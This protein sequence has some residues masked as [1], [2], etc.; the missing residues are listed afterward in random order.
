[1]NYVTYDESGKL[2]GAY[3]Q[4]LHPLHVDCHIEVSGEQYINWTSYRANAARDGIER[5]PPIAPTLEQLRDAAKTGRQ[6]TVDAITVA[7]GDKVFDGDEVSQG[8]M[9]RA[10][11]VADITGQT[12]CTWVMHDNIAAT[13]TKDE[14]SMALALSMQAQANVW[15]I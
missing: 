14:L 12:S 7:V 13:V 1:M 5:M 15:V 6:A 10:L 11:R 8:R 9:A 3:A 4:E 2:T